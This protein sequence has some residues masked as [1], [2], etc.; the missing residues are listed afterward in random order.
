ML[1]QSIIEAWHSYFLI[2]K[3]ELEVYFLYIQCPLTVS[4]IILQ[5]AL[6]KISYT[7]DAWSSA[8]RQPYFAITANWAYHD[9]V[10]GSIKIKACLITFHW[11]FGCHTG[12]KMAKLCINLLDR[13]GTTANV[14]F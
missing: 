1:K 2:L 3:D 7:A 14:F 12:Q 6:G 11:I 8:N 13:A 10:D 4:L 5:S 9:D